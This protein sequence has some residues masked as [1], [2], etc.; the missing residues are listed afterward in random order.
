MISYQQRQCGCQCVWGMS[1][2]EPRHVHRTHASLTLTSGFDAGN[3]SSSAVSK[4]AAIS[5]AVNGSSFGAATNLVEYVTSLSQQ[6]AA[7]FNLS[8]TFV[9]IDPP[10]EL[11]SQSC[12]RKD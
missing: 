5:R 3:A 10:R 4:A 9:G 2:A 11:P 6:P 12:S 7:W 1:A 8:A